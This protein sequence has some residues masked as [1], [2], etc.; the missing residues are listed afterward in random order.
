ML[1]VSLCWEV[2]VLTVKAG[3]PVT[4]I[5]GYPPLYR[6]KFLSVQVVGMC[7]AQWVCLLEKCLRDKNDA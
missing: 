7:R 5:F 3:L 4:P 6:G 2:P 1:L